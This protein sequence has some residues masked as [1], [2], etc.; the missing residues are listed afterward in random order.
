MRALAEGIANILE[1]VG[2]P[3]ELGTLI[4]CG[5][6]LVLAIYLNYK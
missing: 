5:G 1:S 2:I 6:L 4:V 3:F